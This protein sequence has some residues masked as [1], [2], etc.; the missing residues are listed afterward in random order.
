[1]YTTQSCT[2]LKSRKLSW[3]GKC[4]IVRLHCLHIVYKYRN[5][6]NTQSRSTR[7]RLSLWHFTIPIL[8]KSFQAK[9]LTYSTEITPVCQIVFLFC[10]CRKGSHRQLQQHPSV[11]RLELVTE[12]LRTFLAPIGFLGW[13]VPNRF[14]FGTSSRVWKSARHTLESRHTLMVVVKVNIA[15][16]V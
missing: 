7:T 12:I 1:M 10:H 13:F 14:L 9:V 4:P 16:G 8:V 3:R 2:R 5:I 15:G 11:S 6:C